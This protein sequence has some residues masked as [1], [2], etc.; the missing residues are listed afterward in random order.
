ML[1]KYYI[2]SDRKSHEGYA[3]IVIDT[4]TGFF[5][6]V[7]DYGNYAYLWTHPGCE[8][9][10]FLIGLEPDYLHGKLMHGRPDHQVFNGE[11]TKAAIIEGIEQWNNSSKEDNDG[12]D[13]PDYKDELALIKDADFDSIRGFD[14]WC[15]LT[16]LDDTWEYQKMTPEPQCRAFCEKVMP[17]FKKLLE[18]ELAQE[19]K[20]KT[21]AAEIRAAAPAVIEQVRA[22]LRKELESFVGAPNTRAVQDAMLDAAV[23]GTTVCSLCGKSGPTPDAHLHQDKYIGECCWDER[24]KATE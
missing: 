21:L 18:E 16:T 17:R 5:A 4:D 12:T 23:Y 1:K 10:K 20:D 15:N 11:A 14:D 7:S 2:P 9:R 8:F 22:E 13:Q 19:E 3:Y 24:L 6:T